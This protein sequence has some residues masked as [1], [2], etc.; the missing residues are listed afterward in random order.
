MLFPESEQQSTHFEGPLSSRIPIRIHQPQIPLFIAFT[1]LKKKIFCW[2][3]FALSY[4]KKHFKM[5]KQH[6]TA[7]TKHPGFSLSLMPSLIL[8]VASV[9]Q[10]HGFSV[11][12]APS[13]PMHGHCES[14]LSHKYTIINQ[15]TGAASPWHLLNESRDLKASK[16]EGGLESQ[17][18]AGRKTS[19]PSSSCLLVPH[20]N[21]VVPVICRSFSNCEII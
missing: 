18:K 1:I 9:R 14:V 21:V 13:K 3:F 4:H 7:H 6:L 15:L 19:I 16:Q 17:D 2:P 11:A 20:Q 12:P 5:V 8:T 10:T